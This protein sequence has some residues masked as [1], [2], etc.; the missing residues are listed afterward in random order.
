[1]ILFS[2]VAK[3]TS[4][5]VLMSLA[6]KFDLKIEKIDVKTTFLHGDMEEEIYMKEPK[7]FA[8]KA[9]K[10]IVCKLKR[11]L[12]DLKQSPNMWYQ[13]F[14]TYILSFGI[15]RSKVDHCVYSME[16]GDYLIYVALYVNDM[17]LVKNNMDVKKEVKKQLSSK[18]DMKDIVA[19]IFIMGMEI[20]VYWIVRNI[21][22]NQRKYIETILKRFNMQYCK[23]IKVLIPV[24]EKKLLNSV[25]RNKKK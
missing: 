22:L 13:K 6:T 25:Q 10:E 12:Y 17:L 20:K 24:G 23:P 2:L 15:V 4:I 19:T 5:R 7:I 21:W 9:K 1:V 16:E 18:F 11:S 3:L 8:V 14:D